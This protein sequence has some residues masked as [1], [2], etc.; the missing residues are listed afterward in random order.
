M[1]K[2]RAKFAVQSISI[3]KHWEKDKGPISTITLTPV[4]SGSVE[5]TQFYAATP[6]GHIELG[7]VNNEAALA[8]ELGAE[9]YV[10]FT[11]A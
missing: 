3:K 2:V 9:Y 10:D 7:M 1:T 4:T 5:N 6:C 11:K 8:F